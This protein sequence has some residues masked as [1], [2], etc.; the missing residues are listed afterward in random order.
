MGKA[1]SKII[2]LILI[3]TAAFSCP[4]MSADFENYYINEYQE[5]DKE[6]KPSDKVT[7]NADRVSFNDET[8]HALAEGN[9]ILTYD[10][11]SIMAERLDYDADT[12]KVQAMPLPNQQV[13]ITDGERVIKGDNLNYDLN[14]QEG[15]LTGARSIVPVG[16]NDGVLYVYGE[17][18]N[19]MPWELAKERKLVHGEPADY[20][21]E[22]KNV[23]L[24]TCAL[25]HP[26]YRLEAKKISFIPGK[27]LVAKRPRIYLGS[28]YLFTSPLDYVV[29]FKRRA[30]TY[31]FLPYFQRSSTRGAGAGITG[32]I[33]WD[34]GHASIGV[35]WANKTGWEALVGIDQDLGSNLFLSAGFEHSWDDAWR[36]R[37][38]RPRV[39]LS[40]RYNGWDT[41][42][43]WHDN[44]Y[45]EDQKDTKT[46]F[47]GRL[48]RRPELIITTPYFKSSKYSWMVIS[49]AYG[50]FQE[51][52]HGQLDGSAVTRYAVGLK[53]YFERKIHEKGNVELFSSS[54]G[55]A[56]F[57]DNDKSDHE[58]FR[59][60]T[61]LRYN[62][63]SV[64]LGTGYERQSVWGESPMHWDQYKKR[65]R[66]HQ[67]I[68][69]PVGREVFL[70]VRGSYDLDEKVFDEMFYS[71][72]WVTDCMVWDLH[73]RNDRT[74][75]GNDTIGLSLAVKAFPNSPASLGQNKFIDPFDRPAEIP[76]DKK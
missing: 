10:N 11:I 56:F 36:D 42:L 21:L 50:R 64:E 33:G 53:N 72:Q 70:G 65:Q 60:F 2:I 32:S 46:E 1:S 52:I 74:S 62:L 43:R 17:D 58:M 63:G 49:A 47:K 31:S 30:V 39:A 6:T 67:R 75:G 19:V 26:H 68:R 51:T 48:E 20:L 13:V 76:K 3:F 29:Q 5:L 37:V 12:Q 61:G 9:A 69:F 38:F 45:I 71:I 7:L 15:I 41:T 28:K 24:T 66:V 27:K 73:Y 40:Y 57:Y 18:I 55:I 8:G 25:D 54:E 34:T 23:V 35:A 4:A 14:T 16:E 44:E 59:S 22:W